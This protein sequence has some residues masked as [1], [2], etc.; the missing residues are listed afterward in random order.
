MIM[1]IKMHK[2]F[3]QQDINLQKNNR[4]KQLAVLIFSSLSFVSQNPASLRI[5]SELSNWETITKY[6]LRKDDQR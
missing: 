2:L 1:N 6:N 4:N 3:Q 5:S